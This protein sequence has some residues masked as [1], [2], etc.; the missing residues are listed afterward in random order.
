MT[1]LS[2]NPLA[3]FA[4]AQAGR[5]IQPTASAVAPVAKTN[6]F[7]AYS[8]QGLAEIK[9]NVYAPNHA[10][11]STLRGFGNAAHAHCGQNLCLNA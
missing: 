10:G 1:G 3:L 4:S 9:G 8:Q 2:I 6:P 7:A 5:G 11:G